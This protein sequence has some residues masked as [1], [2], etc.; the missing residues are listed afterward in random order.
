MSLSRGKFTVMTWWTGMA[1]ALVGCL[2]M[3]VQV[4]FAVVPVGQQ[5]PVYPLI[6]GGV[7]VA[8]AKLIERHT[9]FSASRV[10]SDA[11]TKAKR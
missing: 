6:V 10:V 2:L 3:L 11:L 8:F 5:W 9:R 7:L 4:A 1:L